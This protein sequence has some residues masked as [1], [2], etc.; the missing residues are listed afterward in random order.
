MFATRVSQHLVNILHVRVRPARHGAGRTLAGHATPHAGGPAAARRAGA[1]AGPGGRGGGPRTRAARMAVAAPGL[2]GS[3]SK[4]SAFTHGP[5]ST[6]MYSRS[7]ALS[8]HLQL[9]AIH[10]HLH[11][12]RYYRMPPLPL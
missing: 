12:H 6:Y 11:H 7:Y 3:P 5:L 2:A 4:A 9:Y 8:T 10:L 1:R